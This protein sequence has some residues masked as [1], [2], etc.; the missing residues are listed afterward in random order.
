MAQPEPWTSGVYILQ[1]LKQNDKA[2]TSRCVWF[3]CTCQVGWRARLCSFKWTPYLH[4]HVPLMRQKHFPCLYDLCCDVHPDCAHTYTHDD[5]LQMK[6]CLAR[7]ISISSH[8]C[9]VVWIVL[10]L[11]FDFIHWAFGLF[12][13]Y[14]I[15]LT[16]DF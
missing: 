4:F 8:Y 16:S 13:K 2:N 9:L 15:M 1:W 6:G 12:S 11:C 5:I 7:I 3:R 10:L 14:K